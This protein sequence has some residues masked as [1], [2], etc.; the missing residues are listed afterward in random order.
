MNIEYKKFIVLKKTSNGYN[1]NY[2]IIKI[3]N[4]GLF[5]G[6]ENDTRDSLS[7][8]WLTH[9]RDLKIEALKLKSDLYIFE[10]TE[11]NF[12][13]RYKEDVSIKLISNYLNDKL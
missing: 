7:V 10:L 13:I 4:E 11:P 12:I 8:N 9:I 5:C 1:P 6:P 2:E 3:I